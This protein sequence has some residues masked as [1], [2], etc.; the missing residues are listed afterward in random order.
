MFTALI[1]K[2]DLDNLKALRGSVDFLKE[3]IIKLRELYEG[4][5]IYDRG[6]QFAVAVTFGPLHLVATPEG[7]V[8]TA[9]IWYRG[10]PSMDIK[11]ND[12]R[13]AVTGYPSYVVPSR[14]CNTSSGD[15]YAFTMTVNRND[16]DL[17]DKLTFM[18]KACKAEGVR[19]KL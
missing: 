7:V 1:P 14:Q 9:T 6:G 19:F 11:L 15:N 5:V 4:G 17:A 13:D 12:T 18:I 3:M 8:V 16:L 10:L 2:E